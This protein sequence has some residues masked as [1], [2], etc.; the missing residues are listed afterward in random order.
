M[1]ATDIGSGA[2]RLQV[3]GPTEKSARGDSPR[4]ERCA[5]PVLKEPAEATDVVAAQKDRAEATDAVVARVADEATEDEVAAERMLNAT[6]KSKRYRTTTA[7]F[8]AE[9]E[10]EAARGHHRWTQVWQ[11]A[12]RTRRTS[13]TRRTGT[14]DGE[15]RCSRGCARAEASR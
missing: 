4:V 10:L 12:A 1:C 5:P 2:N 8:A 15:R 7:S 14:F 9:E 11:S 13:A 6:Q 3:H